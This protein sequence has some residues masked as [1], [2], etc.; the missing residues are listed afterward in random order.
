MKRMTRVLVALVAPVA[1][2][3]PAS[4]QGQRDRC[5]V[6]VVDVAAARKA[7][8]LDDEA[9]MLKAATAAQ[10]LFPEFSPEPSEE[11]IVTKHYPFPGAKLVVTASVYYTDESMSSSIGSDSISLGIVLAPKEVEDAISSAAAASAIAETSLSDK[12]G[13]VR[14]KQ[15]VTVNGK[16][17]LIGIEC[18]CSRPAPAKP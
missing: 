9:A 17:Y 5:H 13:K 18:D 16:T 12:M 4:G 3:G 11:A 7:A 1:L 10:T 6:Y 14:A 2:V 8:D 15:Y